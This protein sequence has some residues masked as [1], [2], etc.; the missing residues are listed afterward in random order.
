[1]ND[2]SKEPV[3]TP[4]LLLKLNG[5]VLDSCGWLLLV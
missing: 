5:A 2:W 4:V 1:V 3:Y